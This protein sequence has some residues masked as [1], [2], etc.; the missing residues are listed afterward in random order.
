MPAKRLAPALVCAAFLLPAAAQEP[1]PVGS[2]GC[3]FCHADI[4]AAF[5]RNPHAVLAAEQ[6]C[7]TCHGNGGNHVASLSAADIRNPGKLAPGASSA[8]CLACHAN[9]PSQAGRLQNGHAT[10]QV[11]CVACHRMHQSPERLL[12]RK[13]A[14]VNETCGGCHPAV[15]A[16]FS[17]PYTH[18]LLEGAISCIDCHNPHN[19]NMAPSMRMVAA[20]NQPQCFTCHQEK[21]GPFLYEHAPVRNEGCSACHEPHGSAN[22]RMLAANEQ[23][24]LC[25][26]CHANLGRP[27]QTLGGTPSAIHDLDSGRYQK[28]SVCHITV[29]GSNVSRELLR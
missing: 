15:R 29:H 8:A 14:V 23:R 12:S 5:A 16:A 17:R 20:A 13:P 6:A 26:Q 3:A 9:T 25:L 4:S 22:P 28:C 18:K 7:E 21:R 2:S 10:N 27:G 19:R 11:A 24:V 1:A